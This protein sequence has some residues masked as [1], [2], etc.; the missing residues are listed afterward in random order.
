MTW[1]ALSGQ[2]QP[3]AR[4]RRR[5]GGGAVRGRSQLQRPFTG[6]RAEARVPQQLVPRRQVGLRGRA[7]AAGDGVRLARPVWT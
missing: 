6:A 1:R 4:V 5:R 3:L 2:A 7:R